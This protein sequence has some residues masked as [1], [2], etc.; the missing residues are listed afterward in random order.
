MGLHIYDYT[1]EI[2]HIHMR[3]IS[4]NCQWFINNATVKVGV[5]SNHSL[6]K[7]SN[8][9]INKRKWDLIVSSALIS[10]IKDAFSEYLF[11][12]KLKCADRM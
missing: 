2:K 5:I 11:S 10:K 4:S 12:L 3:H 7:K 9:N 6:S 1:I 8:S